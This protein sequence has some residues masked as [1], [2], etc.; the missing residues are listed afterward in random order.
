MNGYS[1][2]WLTPELY[3][4]YEIWIGEELISPRE[5]YFSTFMLRV[6]GYQGKAPSELIQ[7]C[8]TLCLSDLKISSAVLKGLKEGSTRLV[9]D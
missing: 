1:R 8:A 2:R 9:F 6:L 7:E 4:L 5:G 3:V